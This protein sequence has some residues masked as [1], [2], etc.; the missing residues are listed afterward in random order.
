MPEDWRRSA[1]Y[2][3]LLADRY[4]AYPK[5]ARNIPHGP[6]TMDDATSLAS[7]PQ[8]PPKRDGQPIVPATPPPSAPPPPEGPSNAQ[9]ALN[10]V[11]NIA[12]MVGGMAGGMSAGG[13]GQ[14]A[15]TGAMESTAPLTGT[16]PDL[17]GGFQAPYGTPQ[18]N[19]AGIM[20]ADPNTMSSLGQ[21]APSTEMSPDSGFDR[22]AVMRAASLAQ[23]VGKQVQ[24]Q[25]SEGSSP[26][27]PPSGGAQML[28]RP[29]KKVG[30]ET[31]QPAGLQAPAGTAGTSRP[32]AL[33]EYLQ[34]YAAYLHSG[35]RSS[36]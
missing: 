36:Y 17:G 4:G 20:S 2:W 5:G 8:E 6:Q 28:P 32:S 10:T 12:G 26:P 13:A 15:A 14:P 19:E 24:E 31:A 30:P 9:V 21:G 35:G 25:P 22:D 1:D 7:P 3:R 33:N 16:R 11:G 29:G 23:A 34:R 27:P 18:Y